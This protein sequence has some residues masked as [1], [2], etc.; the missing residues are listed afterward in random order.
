MFFMYAV[1]N[2][3]KKPLHWISLSALVSN[4]Y[5]TKSQG[6]SNE[7][8]YKSKYSVKKFNVG[9]GVMFVFKQKL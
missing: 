7:L 3:L 4:L 5:I 9:L 6:L 2:I 8:E 1:L